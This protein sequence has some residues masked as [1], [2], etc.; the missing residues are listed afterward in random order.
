M[1]S[2]HVAVVSKIVG[3]SMVLVD[4]SNWYHGRVTHDTPVIDTSPDHDWTSVAVQYP[5]SG[6]FGR[7]SPTYGFVYPETGSREVV[8]MRATG[9]FDPDLAAEPAAYEPEPRAHLFHFAVTHDGWHARLR[10]HR[11]ARSRVAT[12]E[13]RGRNYRRSGHTNR[14]AA[15]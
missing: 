4:Q 9:G 11:A 12:H 13:S 5:G 8:A 15:T 7:D 14:H 2:G 6:D 10:Y 3:P 1:P